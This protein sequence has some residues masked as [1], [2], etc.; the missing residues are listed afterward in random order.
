MLQWGRLTH[1]TVSGGG[2]TEGQWPHPVVIARSILLNLSRTFKYIYIYIGGISEV[3]L[4]LHAV[5][6][7]VFVFRG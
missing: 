4:L 2:G 3:E 7:H 5:E 1:L 6:I